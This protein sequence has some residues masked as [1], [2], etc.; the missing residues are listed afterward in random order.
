MYA[1]AINKVAGAMEPPNEDRSCTN[2]IVLKYHNRCFLEK[3]EKK[4]DNGDKTCFRL[5]KRI[6]IRDYGWLM[7]RDFVEYNGRGISFNAFGF[8]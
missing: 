3:S 7:Y 4:H 6:L 8:S 1:Y 5:K 2:V